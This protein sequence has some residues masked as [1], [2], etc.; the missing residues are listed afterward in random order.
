M[1]ADM[2]AVILLVLGMTMIIVMSDTMLML[3]IDLISRT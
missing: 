2:V 1:I 3:D